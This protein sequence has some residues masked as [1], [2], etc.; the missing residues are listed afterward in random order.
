M[1][2]AFA[3][4]PARLFIVLIVIKKISYY[5]LHNEILSFTY[6]KLQILPQFQPPMEQFQKLK[7][8]SHKNLEKSHDIIFG[9]LHSMRGGTGGN[10]RIVEKKTL[11]TKV[12]K[13]EPLR[14]LK[15]SA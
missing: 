4:T 11:E 12:Y 15:S 7:K 5:F 6:Y 3:G 14:Y 10:Q 13:I 9:H 8:L 2:R 1:N